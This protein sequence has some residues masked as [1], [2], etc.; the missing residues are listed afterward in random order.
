MRKAGIA[1]IGYGTIGTGVIEILQDNKETIQKRTGLDIELKYVVD[2]DW[3]T[4]RRVEIQSAKK[5]SDY[6]EA[7]NDPGV[8]IVVELVGGTGFA[9]TLLEE[10]LKS[11]KSVVTANKALLAEKG[12]ALFDLARQQGKT[13]AFEASVCG[14]I[15]IIR[16]IADA[17]AGDVIQSIYGIV[18]GTTNYILTKMAE[19]N[20]DFE[21]A[22]KQAQKLGFAEADPTLDINGYDAAHKAA[23]LAGLAFNTPVDYQK[24]YAEGIIGID[25]VDIQN[26]EDLGYVVKLLAIAKRYPD[27]TF[28]VRVNP[29]LVSRDNQLS[30]VRN[31][32]NAILLES[33]FLGNSMYYGR[34]AGSRPTATAVVADIIDIARSLEGSAQKSAYVPFQNLSMKNIGETQNRYYVR[35]NVMD[36][37][38]VLSK[39][40][41]IFGNHN[42]S[43]ASV[44]QKERSATDYVPLIMT[45]HSAL[46]K[47]MVLALDEIEKLDFCRKRGVMMRII[48]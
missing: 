29:A 3:T 42:I 9:Y 15:P 12:A 33:T 39:I 8:E 48:E 6:K 16:T 19:E 20:L 11:G 24:V 31:E 27:H 38:G 1:L 18:N 26:A 32:F 40:S 5:I 34:G 37:P 10:S 25:S 35:F 46:E 45:T 2:K 7:L 23:I 4:P 13:I 17:L 30:F 44:V 43:I 22:L 36:K 28:E 21:S 47:N 41:G 14:G